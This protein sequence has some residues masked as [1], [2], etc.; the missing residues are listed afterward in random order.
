[1]T[2]PGGRTL[3][4]IRQGATTDR[5]GFSH[6]VRWLPDPSRPLPRGLLAL[7]PDEARLREARRLLS[8]YPVPVYLALEE[9]VANASTEDRVWR[10]ART[11]AVLSLEDALGHL[12]PGGRLPSEP[13]LTRPS[14]PGAIAV[15]KNPDKIPDYLL[16]AE[17]K[18]AA[19]RV[20]DR[21][22]DWPW[23]TLEDLAGLLNLSESHVSGVC[24]R[25]PGLDWSPAFLWLAASAWL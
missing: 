23:I 24:L 19:K 10:L 11:P 13:P 8:R 17:L 12:R 20:L 15:S 22:S 2:L 9:H 25:L 16:P 18:P 4:V 3:G 6:R 1:M 21:L 14:P 7:M 5:T